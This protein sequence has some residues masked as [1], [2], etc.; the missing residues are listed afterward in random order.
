MATQ[1]VLWKDSREHTHL[2]Q[3]AAEDADDIYTFGTWYGDHEI[4]TFEVTRQR[5]IDLYNWLRDNKADLLAILNA[6]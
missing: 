4:P 3:A 1:Y 6:L 2:T 5:E